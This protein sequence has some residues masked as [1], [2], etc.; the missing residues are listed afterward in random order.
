MVVSH[1]FLLYSSFRPFI[2]SFHCHI[3]YPHIKKACM[4]YRDI[5]ERFDQLEEDGQLAKFFGEVL[6]R[7]TA[8]EE[9]EEE[10]EEEQ[11]EEQESTGGSATVTPLAGGDLSEPVW[12]ETR[13]NCCF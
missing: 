12:G 4:V 3:F 1:N 6:A 13:T 9:E 7:R 2:L 10:E 8:L 5:W 11:Q